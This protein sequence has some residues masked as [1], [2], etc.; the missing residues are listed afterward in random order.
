MPPARQAGILCAGEYMPWHKVRVYYDREAERRRR[1]IY[2]MNLSVLVASALLLIVLAIG[3]YPFV[4]F[5]FEMPA[6]GAAPPAWNVH[7][8]TPD[9]PTSTQEVC[10][11]VAL[12]C[13]IY[14]SIAMNFRPR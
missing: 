6:H 9:W 7:R 8:D 11:A 12:V 2:H 10:A 14:I 4:E 5:L 3:I 1:S 13:L